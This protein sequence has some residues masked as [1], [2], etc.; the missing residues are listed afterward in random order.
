MTL[1]AHFGKYLRAVILESGL[2]EAGAPSNPDSS[3]FEGASPDTIAALEA[4]TGRLP[5]VYTEFLAELGDAAGALFPPQSI[6]RA[7]E[8]IALQSRLRPSAPDAGDEGMGAPVVDATASDDQE[9][10]V[11]LYE[12]DGS[13][14]YFLLRDADDPSVYRVEANQPSGRRYL[15][16]L[17]DTLVSQVWER[18]EAIGEYRA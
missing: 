2:V 9:A 4:V 1:Q 17:S 14:E 7:E 12:A 16:S 13:Y 11:F 10:F 8:M 5:R 18:L 3:R 15:G 6:Y